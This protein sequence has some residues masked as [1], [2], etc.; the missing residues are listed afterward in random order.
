MSEIKITKEL[1]TKVMVVAKAFYD[2]CQ[3]DDDY[4][5]SDVSEQYEELISLLKEGGLGLNFI[6]IAYKW[7][8]EFKQDK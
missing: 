1:K 4:P 8:T 7:S 3:Y 6:D 5:F 2:D